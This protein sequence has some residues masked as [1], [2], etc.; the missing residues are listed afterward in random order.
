MATFQKFNAFVENLAEKKFNLETDT[1]KV[2]LVNSPAPLATNS[3]KADLTEITAQ[4]G[5]SAG[6]A[7]V[8]VAS[9]GQT[10]GTYKLVLNDVTFTASGGSF[11]PFRY[12]V[13]Y[14]DTA[15][16]DELIGFWDYGSSITLGNGES[17][18]ADFSATNG[19]LQIA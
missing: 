7:T 6:G 3:V 14:S 16:S 17:V 19:A 2:M 10:S 1:L 15:A 13:L 4:N 11:G 18:T 12:F 9:A 8:T 5:Y